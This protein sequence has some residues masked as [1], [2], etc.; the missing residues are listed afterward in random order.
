MRG[1]R[2]TK[3]TAC[4]RLVTK[5]KAEPVPSGDLPSAQCH[6]MTRS[7]LCSVVAKFLKWHLL[8]ET[9]TLK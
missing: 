4:P 2:F 5:L 7:G 3:V 9:M 1:L 8:S 6:K